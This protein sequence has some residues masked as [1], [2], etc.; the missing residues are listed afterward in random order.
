MFQ[1]GLGHDLS[2]SSGWGLGGWGFVFAHSG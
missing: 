1:G 2:T